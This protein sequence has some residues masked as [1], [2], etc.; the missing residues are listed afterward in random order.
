MSMPVGPMLLAVGALAALVIARQHPLWSDG[1]LGSGLMPT[2]G[3]GLVLVSSVACL[4]VGWGET[5][6]RQET[7]KVASYLAALLALPLA[8]IA[9][10]MLPGLAL[11]ALAVLVLI[12]SLPL[13]HALLIAVASLAFNWVVFQRLLQVTLPRSA[14]W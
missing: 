13:K 9:L 4:F 2:V 14:L 7:S 6:E 8:V 5:R 10:G 12:E 3:A 1:A 11:F